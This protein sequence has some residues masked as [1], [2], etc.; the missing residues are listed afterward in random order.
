MLEYALSK[1]INN[2]VM[3]SEGVRSGINQMGKAMHKMSHTF[4]KDIQSIKNQMQYEN[5]QHQI[6]IEK[7]R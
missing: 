5:L 2:H 7:E 3:K 6:E 4:R 1:D